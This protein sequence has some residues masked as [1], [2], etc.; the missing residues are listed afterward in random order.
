[1]QKYKLVKELGIFN[2]ILL[3][4]TFFFSCTT[5]I[6]KPGSINDTLFV[7]PIVSLDTKFIAFKG[8][9]GYKLNLEHVQTGKMKT[10]NV[11]YIGTD[12]YAFFKGFPEGEYILKG[13][14][15]LE[16]SGSAQTKTINI[17]KFLK[18]E[19]EKLTLFPCKVVMTIYESDKGA[20]Y[21]SISVRFEEL[22]DEHDERI[23]KFLST[24]K[25]YELWK[26]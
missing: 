1:M 21:S 20:D 3:L 4:T 8:E 12:S 7:V 17:K 18:V 23:L 6:P 16:F 2:F 13:Y 10:I 22:D 24:D 14:I 11:S 5:M 15:P 19:K 9:F 25:N 26:K